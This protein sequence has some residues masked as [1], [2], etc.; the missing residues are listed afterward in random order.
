MFDDC[1]GEKVQELLASFSTIVLQKILAAGDAGRASIAGRLAIANKITVKEHESLLPLAI[2]HRASLTGLLRRKKELRARYQSFG[3]TLGAKEKELDQKFEG[4]VQTQAFLDEN[5]IPDNTVSRLS[6]L[7]EK[8]WQGDPDLVAVVTQGEEHGLRDPLLDR[9]FQDVWPEVSNG[10]FDRKTDTSRGGLLQDLEKRVADQESRLNQWKDFKE[11]ITRGSTPKVLPKA[12]DLSLTR[13]TSNEQERQKRRERDL[14]FSPR[15]SP[16]KSDWELKKLINEDSP[17]PAMP[18]MP[19]F[20]TKMSTS[21]PGQLHAVPKARAEDRNP[22]GQGR[23]S[24]DH[25]SLSEPSCNGSHDSSFSEVSGV[26][27]QEIASPDSA[28]RL[29]G[30]GATPI[31]RLEEHGLAGF[32]GKDDNPSK[33]PIEPAIESMGNHISKILDDTDSGTRIPDEDDVLAEQIISMTLNAAPT[34]AKPTLSLSERTRQSIAFASPSKFQGL[35]PDESPSPHLPTTTTAE[36]VPQIGNT[37]AKT[38]TLLE[39]T[40]Q[41]I[42]LVPS[43]PNPKPRRS[44]TQVRRASQKIYPTNPFET[45]RKQMKMGKGLTP[46]EELFTPGA[47]YESVFKSRPKVAVSPVGTPEPEPGEREEGEGSSID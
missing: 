23:D 26:Q 29:T 7:F 42:S 32:E 28:V 12:Q 46:P 16:R 41:S 37:A 33:P 44:S 39:R 1:K 6:T 4:V 21:A 45:P 36:Q 17:T 40:R 43:N 34:P 19:K 10:S 18:K 27:L 20:E 31:T 38:T 22:E 15:K 30:F 11:A 2:A 35:L 25:L 13:S 3:S 5:E 9:P 14:V 24:V 8:H 47:G